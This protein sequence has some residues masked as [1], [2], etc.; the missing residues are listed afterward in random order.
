MDSIQ[1]CLV[2]K[3]DDKKDIRLNVMNVRELQLTGTVGFGKYIPSWF[4]AW[5][6]NCSSSHRTFRDHSTFQLNNGI[7]GMY[8]YLRLNVTDIVLEMIKNSKN[9]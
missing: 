9:I 2:G 6:I 3:T 4:C 5:K 8:S 7:Q 1:Y